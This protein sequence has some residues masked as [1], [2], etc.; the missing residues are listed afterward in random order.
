M[1]DVP[2]LG[3]LEKGDIDNWLISQPVA[4]KVL[5]GKKYRF[6]LEDYEEDEDKEEYHQAIA[7]FLTIDDSVL[8]QAQDAIYQYYKDLEA[9][10]DEDDIIKIDNPND[11]WRHIQIDCTPIIM[12]RPYGDKAIYISLECECDWEPEHGLQ[13]VFKQGLSINKVGSFDGHLSN[14]D[15]YG[16]TNLENVVYYSYPTN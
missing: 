8:K 9:V 7:N 13:I 2:Y 15:S 11:I 14:A 6:I 1:T 3:Q 16:D 5:G 4:V 10:V 12:R